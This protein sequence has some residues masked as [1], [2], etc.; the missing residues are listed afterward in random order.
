M[1]KSGGNYEWRQ[2]LIQ[3]KYKWQKKTNKNN[4]EHQHIVKKM[5]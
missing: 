5:G 4:T 1:N 3:N 2:F